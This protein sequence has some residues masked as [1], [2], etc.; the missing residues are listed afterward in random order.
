MLA[1]KGNIITL[2]LNCY[3]FKIRKVR[4]VESTNCCLRSHAK[5]E[6]NVLDFKTFSTTHTKTLLRCII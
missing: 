6:G 2:Q 5:L 3:H 1:L 4:F